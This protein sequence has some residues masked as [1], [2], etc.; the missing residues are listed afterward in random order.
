MNAKL[1]ILGLNKFKNLDKN[2]YDVS[3]ANNIEEARNF[4]F[5]DAYDAAIIKYDLGKEKG[6]DFSKYFG[7]YRSILVLENEK[8]LHGNKENFENYH[9]VIVGHDEELIKERIKELLLLKIKKPAQEDPMTLLFNINETLVEIR[10]EQIF[11]KST[12]NEVHQKLADQ[13]KDIKT[14]FEDFERF[15]EQK[16]RSDT[17]FINA[18]SDVIESHKKLLKTIEGNEKK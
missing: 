10:S 9:S 11:F 13:E 17:V 7:P 1:L 8:D 4:I 2:T 5:K 3:I 15:K 14:I 16:N 12:L 18:V 6:V